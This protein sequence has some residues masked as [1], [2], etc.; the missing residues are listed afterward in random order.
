MF[1]WAGEKAAHEVPLMQT[2]NFQVREPSA[3]SSNE[4][5]KG[6]LMTRIFASL[7]RYLRKLHCHVSTLS[8]GGGYPPHVDA[9][10]VAILVLSGTVE[11]LGRRVGPHGIIFY[12]AGEPHGMQNVGD[13][14]ASYLVFE[15]HGAH[16][17]SS[18][19]LK[20]QLLRFM[21]QPVI[22][23]ARKGLSYLRH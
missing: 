14:P 10:D 5:G 22:R 21:P 23:A 16:A 3:D 19:P 9:Y 20:Q 1:K 4:M 13:S 6:L 2:S 7:T 11:T 17:G 18:Q 15:F 12:S 8:P